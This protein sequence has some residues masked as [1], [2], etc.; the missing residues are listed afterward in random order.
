[1]LTV[2]GHA[3]SENVVD[4]HSMLK[5]NHRQHSLKINNI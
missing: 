5:H 1:M 4:L 2:S 3:L